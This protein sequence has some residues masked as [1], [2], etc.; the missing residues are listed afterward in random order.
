MGPS[1]RLICRHTDQNLYQLHC[2]LLIVILHVSLARH[3]FLEEQGDNG[4]HLSRC[5]FGLSE[6]HLCSFIKFENEYLHVFVLL[7][8]EQLV[9]QLIWLGRLFFRPLIVTSLVFLIETC[10]R[11]KT[12][13]LKI[14]VFIKQAHQGFS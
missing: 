12:Y 4:T 8:V 11:L 3:T 1:G 13:R 14:K 5:V 7:I 6:F 2:D 9:E 10:F